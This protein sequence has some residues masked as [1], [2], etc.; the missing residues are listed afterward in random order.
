MMFFG[1]IFNILFN[2]GIDVKFVLVRDCSKY[3]KRTSGIK[4]EKKWS[5]IKGRQKIDLT[6]EYNLE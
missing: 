5:T 4:S 1:T 3:E 2:L 6:K